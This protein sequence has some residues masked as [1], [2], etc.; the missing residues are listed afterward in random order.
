MHAIMHEHQ[1]DGAMLMQGK[2]LQA[3]SV[4]AIIG[5]GATP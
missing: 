3:S 1:A 4:A 2:S 5:F